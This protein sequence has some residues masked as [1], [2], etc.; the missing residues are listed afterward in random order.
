MF[1]IIGADGKQYG[2]VTPDQIRQWIREGRVNRATLAQP[3]GAAEWK[4]LAVLPEFIDVFGGSP[5][6]QM[7]PP[8][9]SVSSRANN[10]VAAGICGI[11][12][13][14][15]GVHK[16]ILGYTSA[17][18]LMLGISVALLV[19]GIV[20]CGITLPLLAGVHI[21]GIIEGIIYLTKSDA[22][23]VRIYVDGRKEWF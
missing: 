14:T 1:N 12:L 22:E 21:I 15:W 2:P 8:P 13:G 5:P 19:L 20:T 6:P 23:F 18:V 16:F 4:A 11:L 10:K 3:V 9:A 7:A 17:G